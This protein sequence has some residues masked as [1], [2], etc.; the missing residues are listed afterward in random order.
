MVGDRRPEQVIRDVRVLARP[1]VEVVEAEVAGLDLS[2][3]RVDT[4]R[5]PIAY[6]YL[7]IAL[8]AELAPDAVPG[9]AEAAHTFYTWEG[10]VRL[11]DAL[12]TFPEAGGRIAVVVT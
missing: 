5:G 2:H 1:G 8:G 6:D 11:R 9:L 7:V 10:S 3:A 12:Q 4:T